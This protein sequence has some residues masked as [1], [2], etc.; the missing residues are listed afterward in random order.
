ME[1]ERFPAGKKYED[2]FTTYKILLKARMVKILPE[3][4]YAY[5][6]GRVG[7]ITQSVS[8]EA[9][10]NRFE[11]S[12]ENIKLIENYPISE[13]LKKLLCSNMAE[14]TTNH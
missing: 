11:A 14:D 10:N 7:Q 4:I 3:D 12:V 9:W 5:I 8:F 2:V 13:D 6:I 1:N